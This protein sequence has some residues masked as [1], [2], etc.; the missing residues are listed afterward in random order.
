MTAPATN[1]GLTFTTSAGEHCET[2]WNAESVTEYV[3][4]VVTEGVV[5]Y[6]DDIAPDIA[7]LQVPSAY[8]RYEIDG[9]PPEA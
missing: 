7:K 6:V 8:H 9:V 2:G 3:Y 5:T 4:E 1:A